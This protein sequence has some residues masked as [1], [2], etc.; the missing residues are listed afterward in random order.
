MKR[1]VYNKSHIRG[2]ILNSAVIVGD[3]DQHSE[4]EARHEL[5]HIKKIVNHENYNAENHDNDIALLELTK[6]IEYK[7]HI[8]PICMP[9]TGLMSFYFNLLSTNLCLSFRFSAPL[10]N[11]QMIHLN[12]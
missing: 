7:K 8:Q 3:H 4:D 2:E 5:L 6:P 1:L 11:L 9:S 10:I 12:V